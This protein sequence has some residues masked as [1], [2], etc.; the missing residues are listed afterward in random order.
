MQPDRQEVANRI[1]SLRDDL[2]LT[3][4]QMA[5]LTGRS[6][7]EYIAQ[8]SG[9]ADFDFTFLYKCAQAFGVDV[10]EILTGEAPKLTGYELTRQGEGL[11]IMRRHGFEYLHQA[12]FF[13]DKLTEPFIVTAPYLEEEQNQPIHLSY[14]RGQEIDFIISGR[15]RFAYEDHIEELSAGDTL[16]YDSS[17]GHGM[18]AIGGEPCI[19]LAIVIKPQDEDPSDSINIP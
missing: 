13:K 8:E 14:H 16:Y 1:R 19:F 10:I 9:E 6:V 7:D 2:E 5:E 15:M 17:R 11:S 12:P 3:V 4:E 18:I